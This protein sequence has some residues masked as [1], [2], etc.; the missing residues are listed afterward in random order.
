MKPPPRR[1]GTKKSQKSGRKRKKRKMTTCGKRTKTSSNP[2]HPQ[3]IV[4]S[5]SINMARPESNFVG[6]FCFRYTAKI[7][8][9][10]STNVYIKQNSPAKLLSGRAMLVETE[11]TFG[12]G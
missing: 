11:S 12:W 5:V 3:P 8:R 4:D 6:E 2:L 1:N 10:Y 9:H 7:M